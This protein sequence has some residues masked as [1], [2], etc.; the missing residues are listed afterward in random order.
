M[1]AQKHVA[2]LLDEVKSCTLCAAHLVDGVR[3]VLQLNP[4]ARIRIA[5]QAPGR[6]VHVWR[7][8]GL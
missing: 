3:P 6:K 7:L 1:P 5:G 2:T 4:R 8:C